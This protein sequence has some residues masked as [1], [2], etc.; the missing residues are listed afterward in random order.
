MEEFV[1]DKNDDLAMRLLHYFITEKNYSPIVLHGATGEIWLENTESNSYE[2]V[3]IVTNYI[4]NNEQFN[5]D[6]LK[7]KEITK[8]IK[9]KTFS[10]SMDVLS[11]FLNL[12]DNVEV[13]SINHVDCA[14]IKKI[15]DLAKYNFITDNYPGITKNTKFKE[16]GFNLFMKLTNDISKKNESEAYKAEQVF[17]PKK[18]IITY[19]LIG[20]NILVFLLTYILGS[21]SE[22]SKTVLDLGALYYPYVKAGEYYRLITATFIH[23][24]IFHLL[25]NMYAL[26]IVGSQIESFYGRAKYLIIYLFSAIMGT[27]FSCLFIKDAISAG[28]SGA[29]FGLFGSLLYFG[30]HYRLYLG[31]ALRSSII[32]LLIINLVLGF[33]LPGID[34]SAHIG[35]L[36]GGTIISMALGV[37]YKSTKS[38]KINGT[39]ITSIFTIFIMYLLFK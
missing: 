36:I 11:I 27:M 26:Y 18:P 15:N 34:I 2:I 37:K 14:S 20:I 17:T 30:Y 16:K 28:A 21:G 22:D 39:I 35:G 33:I 24:G 29:I 23:I 7:T 6:L 10:M 12:N 1:I 13:K 19:L 9:K 4:H 38:E 32:P 31:S 3:R 8:R 25:F 5:Y